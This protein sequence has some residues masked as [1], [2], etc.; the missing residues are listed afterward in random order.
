M[1][2]PFQLSRSHDRLNVFRIQ[3]AVCQISKSSNIA[4]SFDTI[5]LLLRVAKKVF[6]TENKYKLF[7]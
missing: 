2:D 3:A 7:A 1:F 5:Y 6:V 4:T